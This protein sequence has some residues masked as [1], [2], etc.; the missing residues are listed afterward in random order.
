M[1]N[2]VDVNAVINFGDNICRG[3]IA[4]GNVSSGHAHNGLEFK[5]HGA[6]IAGKGS[7]EAA[8]VAALC[9]AR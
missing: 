9:G 3:P 2:S 7:S 8:L 4:L 5:V 1:L 6:G